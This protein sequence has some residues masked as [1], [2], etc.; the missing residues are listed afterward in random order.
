MISFRKSPFPPRA[1]LFCTWLLVWWVGVD[2]KIR[3][4]DTP[5]CH[6]R[7]KMRVGT[8]KTREYNSYSREFAQETRVLNSNSQVLES[9]SRVLKSNP[10]VL[11][12]NS[13]VLN[14]YSREYSPYS[15]EYAQETRVLYVR[16]GNY[17]NFIFRH[18]RRRIA[19]IRCECCQQANPGVR[20]Q[21]R[22]EEKKRR[23]S[24]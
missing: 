17:R 23:P 24:P 10:R 18:F 9:N 22:K 5:M 1:C 8:D 12:S 11:K 19:C 3:V 6:L 4:G 2:R 15:S 7:D 16:P 14:S 21:E 13:R 20:R